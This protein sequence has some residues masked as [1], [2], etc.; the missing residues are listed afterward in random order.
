VDIS[1]T[2]VAKAA[3][4]AATE[5][6]VTQARFEQHDLPSS[7]PSGSFDLVTALFLQSPVAFERAKSLR[8]AAERVASGGLFLIVTH[9]SGAPWSWVPEGTVY[10]TAEQELADLALVDGQWRQIFLGSVSRQ[11]SGSNGQRAEVVDLVIALERI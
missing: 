7:F 2:A 8:M 4:R 11:A 3:Q 5:G 1:S 10:P 9:G 6:L